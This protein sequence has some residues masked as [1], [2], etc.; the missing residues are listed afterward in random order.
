[1]ER[2]RR[3][4][5]ISSRT[6]TP[7]PRK[8][9]IDSDDDTP[10]ASSREV[11]VFT[12]A[13]DEEVEKIIS[14]DE[15]KSSRTSP[16]TS[17]SSPVKSRASSTDGGETC[18]TS[19]RPRSS[20]MDHMSEGGATSASQSVMGGSE[21]ADS[22]LGDKGERSGSVVKFADNLQVSGIPRDIKSGSSPMKS[23]FDEKRMS[24]LSSM[25]QGSEIRAFSRDAIKEREKIDQEARNDF[26]GFDARYYEMIDALEVLD[27]TYDVIVN[28]GRPKP[29]EEKIKRITMINDPKLAMKGSADES[30]P[31]D[32][33]DDD[34]F[35]DDIIDEGEGY[36]KRGSITSSAATQ[37]KVDMFPKKASVNSQVNMFP[38]K[39]SAPSSQVNMFPPKASAPPSQVNMF[40]PKASAPPSQVNM[41][42]PKA[43][44]PPS[45]VNMFPPKTSAP[46]SQVNMFPPKSET[47]AVVDN[48]TS[49]S[50]SDTVIEAPS[51]NASNNNENVAI[52]G[53]KDDQPDPEAS[54]PVH[55]PENNH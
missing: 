3:E 20:K 44:A 13:A 19:P 55:E 11:A 22:E 9:T 1:M 2:V 50:K 32:D 51:G 48:E 25:G 8:Q 26:A 47:K 41:F 27:N 16:D 49:E 17:A 45:Q 46:P 21:K 39:Q 7:H 5:T 37:S 54:Q 40:P 52:E 14:A 38:P 53:L 10:L 24:R 6:S 12:P 36:S 31:V 28:E 33:D 4:S 30:F 34:E 42:P 23:G 18:D 43:S 35:D 29:Q 15:T